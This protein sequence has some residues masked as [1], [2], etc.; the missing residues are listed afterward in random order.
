MLS[1]AV[2]G[3]GKGSNFQS[4]LD[5]IREHRLDARVVCALSDRAD[6]FLLERARRA[7]IPA[8]HVDCAPY[9]TKLDGAAEQQVIQVLR[10]YGADFIALAG[11]MRIVKPGLLG[12]FRHRIVNI[13][14]SLLPA[15]PGLESWK[16]ALAYGARVAGCTVHFVDEGMDTGPIIVQRA[17]EVRDDDTPE[18]LHARIQEQEHLAYPEALQWIAHDRLR[19]DGR[20]VVRR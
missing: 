12:A 17:V 3:S 13:H 15:F 19:I 7:G 11:F 6:A 9:Q 5:A 8:L 20:R 1:L 14:P 4:I 18:T 16:Q 2:I 10:E